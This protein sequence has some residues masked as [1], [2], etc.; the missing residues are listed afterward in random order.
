M[1]TTKKILIYKDFEGDIDGWARLGTSVQKAEMM[2]KDW[3]LIDEFVRD[4]RLVKK[5]LASEV[6]MKFID[7]RLREVCDNAGTIAELKELS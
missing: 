1:L 2:D 4:I 3:F 5:G 7:E 6:F